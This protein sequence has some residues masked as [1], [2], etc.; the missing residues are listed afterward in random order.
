[1]IRSLHRRRHSPSPQ[2]SARRSITACPVKMILM[3]SHPS[4]K[5]HNRA[6]GIR[7][8]QRLK[9]RVFDITGRCRP[10]EGIILYDKVGLRSQ[11]TS[12]KTNPDVGRGND[13]RRAHL[14]RQKLAPP[15]PA[16]NP[17]TSRQA[18]PSS[19]ATSWRR[20]NPRAELAA[21]AFRRR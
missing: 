14:R 16:R 11:M 9:S 4:R 7:C 6:V 19:R 21:E 2:S 1:M 8:L 18:S 3:S 5:D 12:A 17:T 20:L 13:H 15:S 10:K